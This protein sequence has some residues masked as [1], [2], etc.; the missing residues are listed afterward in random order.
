MEQVLVLS[1]NKWAIADE[2]TGE[3]TRRGSTLHYLSDY[4]EEATDVSIGAKPMKITSTV[5]VFDVIRKGGAPAV[6]EMDFRSRAGAEGK[7]TLTVVKAALVKP[8]KLF[9]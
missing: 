3:I 5:E 8:A 4:Q 1:A 7:P 6:Y 2:K 9:A